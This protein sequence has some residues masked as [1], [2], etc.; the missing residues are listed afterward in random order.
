MAAGTSRY[1]ATLSQRGWSLAR[2]LDLAPWQAPKGV[3]SMSGFRKSQAPAMRPGNDLVFT[4]RRDVLQ[5][6]GSAVTLGMLTSAFGAALP[7]GVRAAEN[8]KP[9][10]GG[11]PA[12]GARSADG[13]N[14]ADGAKVADQTNAADGA[15]AVHGAKLGHAMTIVYPAGD[16]IKFDAEYYRDHH[17]KLIMSLYG[18]SI[19]RFEL[20][21]V[22]P[23]AA[24]A[25]Q[26]A[27]GAPPPPKF[28]AAVN[29]WIADLDAFNANNAKHGPELVADVPHF[30][31]AQPTIQYDDVH[32]MMG[33][34]ASAMKVGDTCLTILYPNSAGVR[35]DV[36]YY[37]THHMPLIMRL[38]G[39]K[40]I[41]RFELRKGATG[42]TGGAPT[43]IGSVNIY[44]NDQKAFDAAGAEHGKTLVADVP[45]FSSVMPIAFPTT[46]HGVA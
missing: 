34:P 23:N 43:Y 15:K 25:I 16:N 10:G 39:E 32:G 8:S 5:S 26:P 2:A 37:R 27:P 20:R 35:W 12:G 9:T 46:I 19:K 41:K 31:N 29:I 38:Y 3:A 7:R 13:A 11:K 4:N 36:E 1:N 6:A 33:E 14:A 44:I 22:P 40:A 42:Q 18:S 21:T 45:H 28:S 24:P 30:T 17:L